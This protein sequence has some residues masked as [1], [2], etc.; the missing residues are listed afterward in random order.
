M[1][2][3]NAKVSCVDS[4]SVPCAIHL[5]QT[6]TNEITLKQA[7]KIEGSQV[8][9]QAHESR[10]SILDSSSINT[11]GRS[12]DT[13]GTQKFHMDGA[14]YIGLGGSCNRS[15][16]N[17][18]THGRYD[19]VPQF[20][21]IGQHENQMGSMGNAKDANTA[22]GGRIVIIAD[23]IVATGYGAS[24][25]ANAKPYENVARATEFADT[26]VGGSGGYIYVRTMNHHQA[27]N[28]LGERFRVEAKGGF[29]MGRG[30]GGSGGIVVFEGAFNP[31][32]DQVTTV[33]GAAVHAELNYDGCGN[34]ASGTLYY[35]NASRLII[36]NEE[37]LSKHITVLIPHKNGEASADTDEFALARTVEVKGY[38]R[39][40]INSL[41]THHLLIANLQMSKYTALGI[42]S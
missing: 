35:H 20:H 6:S 12:H 3:D 23:S 1:V 41:M 25:Q 14:N 39:V 22:G 32:T 42:V 17:F 36:D 26:L 15:H 4:H 8:I 38:A 16:H 2:F 28:D 27:E 13:N 5:K 21:N 30:Y 29:G 24:L 7:T 33:G 31:N 11:S 9:I 37:R 18:S 10:V 40:Y 19:S 34:G